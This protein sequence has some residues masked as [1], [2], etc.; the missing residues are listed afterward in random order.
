MTQIKRE[1][2]E[3]FKRVTKKEIETAVENGYIV[4]YNIKWDTDKQKVKLPKAIAIPKENLDKD[5]DIVMDGADFLS[6]H[7][8]WCVVSFDFNK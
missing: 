6:N 3:T 1:M 7:Y 8:G 2:R 5:F 4:I